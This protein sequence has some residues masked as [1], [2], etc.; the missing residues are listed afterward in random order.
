MKA[1]NRSSATL[2]VKAGFAALRDSFVHRLHA[3]RQRQML[4]RLHYAD[5][6]LE[7]APGTGRN[8]VLY[9]PA[10][11]VY[12]VEPDPAMH[13][14]IAAAARQRALHLRLLPSHP[15]SLPLADNSVD[16]VVASM[17]LHAVSDREAVLAEIRRVL[18][19]GG[20]FVFVE[21]GE[22]AGFFK[23]LAIRFG[24]ARHCSSERST[25]E[26]VQQSGFSRMELEQ[27]ALR[28]F[29]LLRWQGIAGYAVK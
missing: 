23:R 24:T 6:L 26:L 25:A 29:G 27:L 8:F 28:V 5:V 1:E 16:V 22:S 3:A 13:P 21:R 11:T 17:A 9:P 2:T 19:P 14:R 18:K 20:R 7:I 10:A 4:G 12:A 15:E